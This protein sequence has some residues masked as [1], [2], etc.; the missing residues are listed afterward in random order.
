MVEGAGCRM[1]GAGCRVQGAGC[2]VQGAGCE[3]ADH[4]EAIEDSR[5]QRPRPPRALLPF[6][7]WMIQLSLAGGSKPET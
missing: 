1:Q 3:V 2:R 4:I 5:V 7:V 6:R